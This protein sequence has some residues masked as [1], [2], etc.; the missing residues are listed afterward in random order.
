MWTKRMAI[1]QIAKW[2]G[3]YG[4]TIPIEVVEQFMVPT[5]RIS[6]IRRNYW[7]D[8]MSKLMFSVATGDQVT[9]AHMSCGGSFSPVTIIRGEWMLRMGTDPWRVFKREGKLFAKLDK[10][11]PHIYAT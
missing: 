9:N 7:Y 2:K 10:N 4:K 3:K 5:S 11:S 1:S 8:P 6:Y